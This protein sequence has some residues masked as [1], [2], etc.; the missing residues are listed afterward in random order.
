MAF[1]CRHY[2]GITPSSSF[3]PS[4]AVLPSL[5]W[6]FEST[7][8][9]LSSLLLF[10]VAQ[11]KVFWEINEIYA[12]GGTLWRFSSMKLVM[13]GK[14]A[15]APLGR[16]RHW[17]SMKKQCVENRYT[18][19]AAFD[20]CVTATCAQSCEMLGCLRVHGFFFHWYGDDMQPWEQVK[21]IENSYYIKL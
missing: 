19:T 21:F 14:A 3:R 17:I 9:S 15:N 16:T 8:G 6:R 4:F 5:A 10:R 12:Q 7:A 1:N 20:L 2:F 13:Q 18:D 11:Q